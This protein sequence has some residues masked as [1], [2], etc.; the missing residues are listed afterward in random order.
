MRPREHRICKKLKSRDSRQHMI[1]ALLIM[2]LHHHQRV[3]EDSK[4]SQ[5]RKLPIHVLRH[6]KSLK[7]LRLI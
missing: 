4:R 3:L 5:K 6:N 7:L 2:L 1:N